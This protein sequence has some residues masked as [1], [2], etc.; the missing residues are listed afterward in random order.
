MTA[1]GTGP[2]TQGKRQTAK[3]KGKRGHYDRPETEP[4]GGDRGLHRA[5]P[6][7]VLINGEFNDEDGVLGPKADQGDKGHLKIGVIVKASQNIGKQG[8]EDR[9]G[10][11][12]EHCQ[13]QC[14]ALVEPGEDHEGHDQSQR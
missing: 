8:S 4:G 12:H 11:G 7:F 5:H 2:V 1:G 10:N 13:R 9:K 3:D 6:L 14:K